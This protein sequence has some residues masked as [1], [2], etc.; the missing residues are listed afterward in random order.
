MAGGPVAVRGL[1]RALLFVGAASAALAVAGPDALSPF[2]DAAAAATEVSVAFVVD[3][4]GLGPPVVGCVQVPSNDN[5][6]EALGAFT[7]QHGEVAPIYNN[8]GLLCSINNLPGNAPTVCGQQVPG[9]YDYWSYWHGTTGTWAYATTGAFST[10]QSGDVEGWRFETA[11][12]SNPSDPPPAPAPS[13]SGI[14]G[15]VE[16]TPS[17]LTPVTTA[18]P[19]PPVPMPPAAG[20]GAPTSRS[21]TGTAGSTP[22]TSGAVGGP[23]SSTVTASTAPPP[24]AANHSTGTT[25]PTSAGSGAE[26]QSLRADPT[27]DGRAG[28]GSGAVPGLIG[29]GLV[30]A[31]AVGAVLGWRRRAR[32]P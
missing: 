14:C 11:G 12:Q 20:S 7:A 27:A 26:A 31:L 9:G 28:S 22:P 18:A 5:G 32:T 13:Y 1:V 3:F 6:Y 17:T 8:T 21:V 4:G 10:V 30:V 16:S 24:A 15:S 19:A 29:A 25:S 2:K 23:S